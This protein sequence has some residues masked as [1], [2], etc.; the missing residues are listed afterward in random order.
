[1]RVPKH[2][3]LDHPWLIHE[4][5]PDFTLEDVWILPEIVGEADDFE[6]VITLATD[7]DPAHE[8]NLPARLL[9]G[10]RDLLGR[11]FDLGEIARPSTRGRGLPI[12]GTSQ[13]TLSA[14]LSDDLRETVRAVEFRHLPFVPLFKTADEFA[15]E[16]SNKTVHGI[17][18]LAWVDCDNGTY[19]GQMAV[20]VKPRGGFGRAYM[21]FIKPFRYLVVY[22]ALERQLARSWR[23]RS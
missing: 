1:M 20:Y 10:A 17:L 9:W 15:A 4:I 11:W 23:N 6:D 3:H 8:L 22:P 21:A 18:H 5:V 13:T 16:I 14:R 2:T 7:G 19:Q 12:P